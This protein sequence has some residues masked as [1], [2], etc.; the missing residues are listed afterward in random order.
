MSRKR[1]YYCQLLRVA[2]QALASVEPH[3]SQRRLF[4]VYPAVA[5]AAMGF[6]SGLTA[7]LNPGVLP[8]SPACV[9]GT[10]RGAFGTPF[11][12]MGV[13]V[14]PSFSLR[15]I[16]GRFVLRVAGISCRLIFFS[17]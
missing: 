13:A 2:S 16:K 10:E 1:P 8:R 7:V 3:A 6:A 17:D 9:I 14:A 5:F 12:S 15:K 11:P 4:N